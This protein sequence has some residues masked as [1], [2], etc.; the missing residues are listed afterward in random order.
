VSE[1]A[2]AL[3]PSFESV[4]RA[5][6]RT[7]GFSLYPIQ[8]TGPDVGAALATYLGERGHPARI[9]EPVDDAGWR[10]IVASIVEPAP[11]AGGVVVVIG[12]RRPPPGIYAG[13]LVLNQRRD[14]IVE[15]LDCPLLWCGPLEFL[16]ATWEGAPDFWSIRAL[17][18]RIE[19]RAASPAESTLWAGMIVDAAPERLREMLRTAREQGDPLVVM[20][21]G[22][23]LVEALL[24]SGEYAEAAEL[25]AELRADAG[26][27]TP[28]QR[29]ILELLRARA[30]MPLGDA[31][32]AR[33]A[34]DAAGTIAHAL[35][36]EGAEFGGLLETAKGNVTVQKD[37]VLAIAAYDRARTI[38]QTAG[39]RR[40][41]AVAQ[42]DLGVAE[43]ASGE[44]EKALASLEGALG[45]LRDLG[46]E[47]S[48]ARCLSHLG[49]VHATLRDSR[50]AIGCFEEGL[51]LVRAHGDRR[52][53]ARILCH[54]AR[55]YL[56]IGDAEKAT[57]DATRALRLAHEL[58]DET[59]AA[60]AAEVLARARGDGVPSG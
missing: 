29:G 6:E 16:N 54:L 51:V 28:L 27:G 21:V 23:Q 47:R 17:T 49:R 36:G 14:S 13:L 15:A 56:G 33:D 60:R 18:I 3:E 42:A 2:A 44:A 1:W 57:E 53:E 22:M 26:A 19:E 46:D 20:R 43:L 11:E 50:A 52:G 40:N 59:S 9:V 34:I 4:L 12:A 24:S 55:V 58:G 41:E 30:A 32:G 31:A 39:D 48:E 35:S 25:T 5:V 7:L 38:F 37:A 45:V 10:A 8:V